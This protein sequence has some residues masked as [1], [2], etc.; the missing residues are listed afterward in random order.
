MATLASTIVYHPDGVG[1]HILKMGE[2]PDLPT[3]AFLPGLSGIA[4]DGIESLG[5][6]VDQGFNVASMSFRGRGQSTTPEKG[7]SIDCHSD[8]VGLFLRDIVGSKITLVANSMSTI[9]VVNYLLCKNAAKIDALVI[10]DHPLAL[11]KLKAGWAE[12]AAKLVINGKSI[13]ENVRRVVLGEI[14]RESEAI[15]FYASYEQLKIPTLLMAA[16]VGKGLLTDHDLVLY[17]RQKQTKI[18]DFPDS[19]H[20]IRLRVPKKYLLTCCII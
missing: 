10:V 1:I 11:R 9:Y 12:E 7:Y 18:V 15:D 5:P 4:E 16:P 3:L 6:C 20:F 19:D 13:L 17:C 8:D 2:N 14:E